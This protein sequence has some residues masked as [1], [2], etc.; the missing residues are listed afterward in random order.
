VQLN[1]ADFQNLSGKYDLIIVEGTYHQVDWISQTNVV[2]DH[3]DVT[4]DGGNGHSGH[5]SVCGGHD[6]LIN[7]GTIVDMG[8]HN[9]QPV[10]DSMMSLV[11][12]VEA[13]GSVGDGSVALAPFPT[14]SGTVHGLVITGD[15]YD[16]NYVAQQNIMSDANIVVQKLANDGA[17]GPDG[18]TQTV[19]TGH[20]HAT[21]HAVIIDVGSDLSPHLQ[22]HYY[23]DMILIQTNIITDG[24]KITGNDPRELAS[25]LVAF[26]GTNSDAHHDIGLPIFSAAEMQHHSDP[27]AGILH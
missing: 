23:N 4:V 5:Q 12:G 20:D 21:N 1:E 19:L 18:A 22:G 6:S 7:D 17:G 14:L 16:I 10:S 26:T 11:H 8:N 15:Y 2:L 27:M 24:N 9:F 13:G 3:Y 25:E